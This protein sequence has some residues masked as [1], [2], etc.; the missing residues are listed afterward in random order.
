MPITH[1]Q[2]PGLN[3]RPLDFQSNVLPAEHTVLWLLLS[4]QECAFEKTGELEAM[5]SKISPPVTLCR[6]KGWSR[7]ADFGERSSQWV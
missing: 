2:N 4:V 1:C 7:L 3:Q 5:P 6:M